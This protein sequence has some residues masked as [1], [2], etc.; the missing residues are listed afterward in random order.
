MALLSRED[1]VNKDDRKYE[2]VEVPEWG[3][4]VRL[5]SMSGTER[6]GFEASVANGPKGKRNLT[7][8]RARLVALCAVDENGR[9]L[10]SNSQDVIMLG[11]KSVAA[12]Q[13]LFNKANEMNGL[14]EKDVEEL[15]EDFD[16]APSEGS[17]TDL[18]VTSA[19]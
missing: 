19:E 18:P 13:R 3:G 14:T 4:T 12:L 1:I 5:R 17:T 8:L 9:R 7:N 6:D 16:V 2:D 10:F 15:V 11:N